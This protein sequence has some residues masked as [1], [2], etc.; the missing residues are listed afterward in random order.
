LIES[1]VLAIFAPIEIWSLFTN[2]LNYLMIV[3]LFLLE[4]VYRIIRFR[5]LPSPRYLQ[6]AF[7]RG[8]L[9]QWRED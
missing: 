8:E 1:V 4:L 3:G 9:I 2:L 7:K 5:R 6:Q